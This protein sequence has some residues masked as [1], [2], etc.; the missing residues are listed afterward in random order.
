[1]ALST[2]SAARDE[3]NYVDPEKFDIERNERHL[4]L[5][6]GVHSCLGA[7]VARL[8]IRVALEEFLKRFPDWTVEKTRL[9]RV[10]T[11][12]VRGFSNVPI[13]ITQPQN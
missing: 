11:S 1:M 2:A 3:R 13:N 12:T 4:S 9:K 5:G 8:E 7:H 10:R 6:I